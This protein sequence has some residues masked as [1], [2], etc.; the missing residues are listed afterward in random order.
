MTDERVKRCLDPGMA[1]LVATTDPQGAPWCCRGTALRSDDGLAS[2]TVY[3]PMATSQQIIQHVAITRRL[4]IA[5]THVIEHLSFQ[6]KGQIRTARAAR[7][8][9]AAFVRSRLDAF[10]D[11]LDDIGVPRRISKTMAHWPAFAL[12]MTVEDVFDQT[13]GPKAGAR[14]R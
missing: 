7:D 5:I 9:E 13:P 3:V 4:A 12:E 11:A 8:D 10:A 2:V 6:L 14:L 1:I